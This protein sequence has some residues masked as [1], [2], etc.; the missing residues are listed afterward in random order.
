MRKILPI[1]F[2]FFCFACRSNGF[3]QPYTSS[4]ELP[5]GPPE[6]KAGWRAGCRTAYSADARGSFTGG[7]V[8]PNVDFGDGTYIGNSIFTSGWLDSFFTCHESMGM[9]MN[10]GVFRAPLQQ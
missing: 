6:Y 10:G 5:E 8:Y 3:Y 9:F 2:L 1:L 4:T 7:F